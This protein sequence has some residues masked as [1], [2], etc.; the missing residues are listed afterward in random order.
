MKLI[1]AAPHTNPW[2]KEFVCFGCQ[3]VLLIEERD[4]KRITGSDQRDGQSWD[5]CTTNC[6]ECRSSIKIESSELPLPV[7]NRIRSASW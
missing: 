4:L 7:K 6:S 1:K 5:Y 3:A 2:T